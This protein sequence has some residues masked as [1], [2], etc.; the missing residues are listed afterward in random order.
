[1]IWK[2]AAEVDYHDDE[3][4]GKEKNGHQDPKNDLKIILK[5]N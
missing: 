1:L 5:N 3:G 2:H 4:E